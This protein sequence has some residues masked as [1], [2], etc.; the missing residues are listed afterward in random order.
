MQI[1][2]AA[3]LIGIASLLFSTAAQANGLRF[4][5]ELSGAQ[6]V[7]DPLGG[8]DTQ[9]TGKAKVRFDKGLTS[10]NVQVEVKNGVDVVAAHIHCAPAGVNGSIVVALFG[11]DPRD[12]DGRLVKAD[13]TNADVNLTDPD[14]PCGTLINNVA[15]LLAALRDGRLYVN[16]HTLQNGAGEVR[17][18][19]FAD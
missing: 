5:A 6:E 16:V 11:G 3:A 4:K 8:V 18:Q 7:T 13:F 15:S 10:V 19:F 9:T 17:G 2:S 12:V 1:R 14:G